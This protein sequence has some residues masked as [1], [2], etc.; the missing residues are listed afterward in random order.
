MSSWRKESAKVGL[1][2]LTPGEA[3]VG[4]LTR[5]EFQWMP[6]PLEPYGPVVKHEDVSTLFMY[7]TVFL[8]VYCVE[9]VEQR[10]VYC[11]Y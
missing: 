1:S 10:I 2:G 6:D 3:A 4:A 7:S 9:H 11:M 8:F 5:P